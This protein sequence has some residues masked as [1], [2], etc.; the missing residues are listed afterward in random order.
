MS[1]EV[2]R[3]Q[4]VEDGRMCEYKTKEEVEQVVQEECKI[5]FK[6]A[7]KAPVTKH[8]LAN[9][10]RYLEDEELAKSIVEG[11]YKIPTDLDGPQMER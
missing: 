5:R 9:K 11:T 7:H 4:R 8:A 1:L 3:V 2:L 10:F 6:L